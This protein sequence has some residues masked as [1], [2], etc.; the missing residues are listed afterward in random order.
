MEK[1]FDKIIFRPIL[2]EK[3]TM[4]KDSVE[5]YSFEVH[6]DATK[7]DV[8]NVIQKVYNVK[9][10]NVNMVNIKGKIKKRKLKEGKKRDWKKAYIKLKKGEKLAIFEGV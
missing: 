5:V 9:V 3:C 1:D 6:P 7:H 2:S 10:D 8:K 4:L